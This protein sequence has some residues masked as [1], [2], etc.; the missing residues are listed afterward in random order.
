[1]HKDRLKQ[2]CENKKIDIMGVAP[3]GPYFELEKILNDRK[4]K[5]HLTGMEEEDINNSDIRLSFKDFGYYPYNK[6]KDEY[7][8]FVNLIKNDTI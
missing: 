8:D 2:I 7:G 3:I 5:E 6:N 1:M 4:Q